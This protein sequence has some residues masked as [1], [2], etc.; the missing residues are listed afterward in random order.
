MHHD[1]RSASARV[2]VRDHAE[3]NVSGT[4]A[5]FGGTVKFYLC[6]PLADATTNCST[7]GV[8]IGA[9]AGETVNGTAGAASLNSVSATLTKAGN[10]CWRAEY[11]GDSAVGSSCVERPVEGGCR[12]RHQ[13]R[14]LRGHPGDAYADHIGG[15]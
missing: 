4:T 13:I 3:I 10:Y 15:L 1:D 12:R 11:S 7:G 6:G 5:A 9:A 2:S 14:V 8:Q